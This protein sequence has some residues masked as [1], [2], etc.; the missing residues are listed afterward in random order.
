MFVFTLTTSELGYSEAVLSEFIEI[1]KTFKV[2][3]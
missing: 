2:K 3:F 1:I